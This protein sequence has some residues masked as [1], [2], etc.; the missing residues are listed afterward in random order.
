[1]NRSASSR[2]FTTGHMT[3]SA[4]ASSTR[5]TIEASF[6]STRT[7]GTVPVPR[8]ARKFIATSLKSASVCCMSQT[9][10]SKPSAPS[11]VKKGSVFDLGIPLDVDGPQ[12]GTGRTNPKRL[13]LATGRDPVGPGAFRYADD[14]ILMP[15]QAATQWDGLSHVWYDDQLY[16][17]FP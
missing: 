14:F 7:I 15:L 3:P 5:C 9:I 16:N 10:E 8:S 1:M 11:L 2:L 17:G 4:P 13:M 6:H 12:V